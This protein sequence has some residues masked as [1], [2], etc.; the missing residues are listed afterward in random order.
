MAREHEHDMGNICNFCN[1][2]QYIYDCLIDIKNRGFHK[3]IKTII[4]I[5]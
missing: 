3:I 1:I 2:F 4:A 5:I